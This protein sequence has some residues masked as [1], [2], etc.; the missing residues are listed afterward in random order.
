MLR[1]LAAGAGVIAL[2]VPAAHGA[3]RP[4]PRFGAGCTRADFSSG[5]AI[6]RAERCGPSTG[7]RAVVVLH[8]CGGFG[9]FDHRLAADLPAL[10][11]ATL[12]VDYF[13]PTPAPP[14]GRGFCGAGGAIGSAFPVWERIARDAAAALRRHY[15]HVGAA[16]WSLGAGLALVSA[17]DTRA[18]DAVAAFSAGA[19][20]PV[21]ERARSLPP[22]IFLSGGRHD[23]I[24][25][26]DAVAL[27][28]AALAARV[29]TALFVYPDGTHA[30][31]GR[32]GV[33]GRARA[34][35]FLRRWLS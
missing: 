20:G 4:F 28:E 13:G 34:A 27:H 17:E 3:A 10:G 7:P 25:V 24:P 1:R 26:A 18:F 32:Q 31:S 5:G 23:V 21:L 16:G 8:G 30:W 12:Y 22:T 14:G 35:A 2:V 15:E 33:V 6:V 19:F 29:P 11:L 9:T